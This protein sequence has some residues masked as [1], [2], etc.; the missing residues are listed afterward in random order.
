MEPR[1]AL[2]LADVDPRRSVAELDAVRPGG[3][4]TDEAR[5][6]C[7][8]EAPA[9]VGADEVV[10]DDLAVDQRVPRMRALVLDRVDGVVDAKDCDLPPAGLD[11]RAT[12]A[13]EKLERNRDAG[14]HG[15]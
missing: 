13:L 9:V 10:G 14:A 8:V 2:A 1:A 12:V 3:S 11:E 7:E 15:A 5:A 4:L 6:G